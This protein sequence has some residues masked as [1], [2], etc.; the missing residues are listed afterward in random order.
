MSHD[1]HPTPRPSHPRTQSYPHSS[2][3]PRNATSL[4]CRFMFIWT[5]PTQ[6]ITSEDTNVKHLPD[7]RCCELGQLDAAGEAASHAIDLLPEKGEQS[8]VYESHRILH[9]HIGPRVRQRRR[10]TISRWLSGSCPLS[11]G[12]RHSFVFITPWRGYLATRADSTT[13]TF[14]D[15]TRQVVH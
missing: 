12:T 2:A 14:T 10:F 9:I 13:H 15:R 6:W 3:Q 4:V 11:T 7:G 5:S 1:T 8:M